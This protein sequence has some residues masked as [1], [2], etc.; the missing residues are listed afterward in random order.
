METLYGCQRHRYVTV[1]R[2][3]SEAPVNRTD[4]MYAIVESLRAAGP[5]GRTSTWLSERFSVSAR[6]IKRD[7]GALTDAGTPIVGQDGRGGGYQLARHA[8]VSAFSFTVGEAAAVAV[9]IAA[10]PGLPFAADAHSALEK[11]TAAMTP[12]QR[13]EV[14]ALAGRV[15]M[16]S[17]ATPKRSTAAHL[18]DEALR[19]RCVARIDYVDADGDSSWRHI[20]PLIFARTGGHW[21]TLAWCRRRRGGRWFRFDRIR[22]VR[23][24]RESFAP[25][26]IEEVFG[27]PPDDAQPVDLRRPRL[28]EPSGA[29]RPRKA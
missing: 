14:E 6:T 4:R 20:E 2:S 9:A 19:H 29:P 28:R 10:A 27:P 16:R 26:E 8:P 7:I 21:Y 18:L 24:T 25:R 1:Y 12:S 17:T 3:G 22:R 5:R 15:W 13:T 11:I 23:L